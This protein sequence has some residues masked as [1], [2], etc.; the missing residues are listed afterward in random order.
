MSSD[1][2]IIKR[3]IDCF[4]CQCTFGDIDISLIFVRFNLKLNMLVRPSL[5]RKG[6]VIHVL[7]VRCTWLAL[8]TILG[9]E[10]SKPSKLLKFGFSIPQVAGRQMK[11]R[12]C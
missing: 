5:L 4:F 11:Y 7:G 8:L 10:L 9:L 6:T 2:E 12:F 3:P 1:V